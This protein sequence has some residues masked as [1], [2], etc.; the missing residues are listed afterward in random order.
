MASTHFNALAP[1]HSSDGMAYHLSEVLIYQ[2]AHG[3]PR[4]TTD[5]YANLSQAVEMLY[6][7]AFEFGRHSAAALVHLAF[8][9]VLVGLVLSYG[10]RMGRPGVGVAAALFT[11]TS[12]V[13][14][15]DGT[16]AYIDVALA[17]V[18]FAVFYALQIWDETEDMRLL[19]L[20]GGL[21][22]FGYGVKYTAILALPYAI[23]FVA[24]RLRRRGQPVLRAVTV[25][26]LAAAAMV[27]PWMAKDWIEVANPVYPFA[28]RIFPNPYVHVSFVDEWRQSLSTY[29][30][31]SKWEIPLAATVRGGLAGI[32]GPVFLLTPLALLAL[33]YKEGRR[34]LVAAAIFEATYFANIGTRFL[35]SG[36]A[37]HGTRDRDGGR[38]RARAAAGA[39]GWSGDPVLAKASC[40][41]IRRTRGD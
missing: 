39:G 29:A 6:L 16:T 37:I 20:A 24:W 18:V 3:F 26:G 23:G 7:F 22:G 33:R 30:L 15:R 1:E 8:F 2:Q 4:I 5:I 12:P 27:V 17:C 32:L 38:E 28:D 14:M 41:G 36:R 25:I 40:N 35:N 31:P 9:V 11:C 21:A 13:M 19:V 34:L 10:R